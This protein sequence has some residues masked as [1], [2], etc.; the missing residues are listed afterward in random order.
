MVKKRNLLIKTGQWPVFVLASLLFLAAFLA[1]IQVVSFDSAWS[2]G[3]TH[4]LEGWD[5]IVTMIAV[6]IWAAQLRGHAVWLLPLAFVGVMSLGGIAGAAGI[7][8]PAVESI[9]LLSCAVFSLL[10]IR[11]IRFSNKINLTIVAFFAFF[12]GFAHGQ[13]IS[14]SASLISY[15]IGFMLAT[16]LLHGAGILVAKLILFCV[17]CFFAIL[18]P[19]LAQAAQPVSKASYNFKPVEHL[20]DITQHASRQPLI[21]D[22]GG[23]QRFAVDNSTGTYLNLCAHI[24]DKPDRARHKLKQRTRVSSPAQLRTVDRFDRLSGVHPCLINSMDIATFSEERPPYLALIRV[25]RPNFA[26]VFKHYFPDINYTPGQILLSNG[27]GLTSPPLALTAHAPV[28]NTQF[29]YAPY[30]IFVEDFVLHLS[31]IQVLFSLSTPISEYKSISLTPFSR[32]FRFVG[33][34]NSAIPSFRPN[35]TYS[36]TIAIRVGTDSGILQPSRTT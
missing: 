6:G 5:H 7:L 8:L 26:A 18:L 12:H 36:F 30:D 17:T 22:Y 2:H 21:H 20:V 9:I 1:L 11:R 16:L 35:C 14:A 13:E 19:N 27:T 29:F 24:P 33:L 3:F 4:P 28:R 25:I 31:F 34:A 32:F 15:S 10:I 23:L